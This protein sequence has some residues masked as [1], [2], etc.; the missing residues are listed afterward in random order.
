M[1]AR[2]INLNIAGKNIFFEK[3]HVILVGIIKFGPNYQFNPK[4]IV[5]NHHNIILIYTMIIYGVHYIITP[6]YYHRF[7]ALSSDPSSQGPSG[8]NLDAH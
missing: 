4:K 5:Y 6:I 2:I 3:S 1:P 7:L 8:L